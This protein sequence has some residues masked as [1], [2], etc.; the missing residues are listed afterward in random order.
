M[1][2]FKCESCGK[3]RTV[4]VATILSCNCPQC[5][6]LMFPLKENEESKSASV[7]GYK[8]T[9]EYIYAKRLAKHLWE[10]HYKKKAP[11]WEPLPDLMGIL[12]Q[13]DNMIAGLQHER[14]GA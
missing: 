5:G 13:I 9:E 7:T 1:R 3:K 12:S 10:N 6:R 14:S 2:V 11:E 8:P 4:G